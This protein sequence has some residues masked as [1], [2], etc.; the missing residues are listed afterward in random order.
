M[1]KSGNWPKFTFPKTMPILTLYS[2]RLLITFANS[3]DQDQAPQN[4]GSDLNPNCLTFFFKKEDFE[5]ISR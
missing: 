3:F 5:K 1:E 2:Y 4:V